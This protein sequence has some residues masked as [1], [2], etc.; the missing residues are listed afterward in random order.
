MSGKM[1][2]VKITMVP[3]VHLAILKRGFP[4]FPTE[5]ALFEF[6]GLKDCRLEVESVGLKVI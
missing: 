2:N 1:A 3:F 5:S 4:V 6:I